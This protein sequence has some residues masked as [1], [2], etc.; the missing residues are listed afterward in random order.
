MDD[1]DKNFREIAKTQRVVAVVG[2]VV[3][4]STLAGI[5][6]LAKYAIDKFAG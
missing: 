4:I 6:L 1:F 2:L 3:T 5:G